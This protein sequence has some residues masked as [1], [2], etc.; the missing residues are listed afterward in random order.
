MVNL[1]PECHAAKCRP[2][3]SKG[4]IEVKTSL[5]P[6]RSFGSL[7]IHLGL[8]MLLLLFVLKGPNLFQFYLVIA[9]VEHLASEFSITALSAYFRIDLS[10]S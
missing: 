4:C 9:S 10:P 3:G 1:L 8:T 5:R 2:F 6:L 7:G